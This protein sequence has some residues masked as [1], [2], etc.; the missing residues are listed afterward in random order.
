MRPRRSRTRTSP[1]YGRTPRPC[2]EAEGIIRAAATPLASIADRCDPVD[3]LTKIL[4][5]ITLAEVTP[6]SVISAKRKMSLPLPP[7]RTSRPTPP[8]RTSSPLPPLSRSSPPP[9]DQAGRRGRAPARM[10]ASAVPDR[11][12]GERRARQ[13]LDPEQGVAAGAAGVRHRGQREIDSHSGSRI[14]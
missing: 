5:Q 6:V 10:L 11:A 12:V 9:P 4:D 8:V 13:V 2:R 7:I 14:G 1:R 3:A